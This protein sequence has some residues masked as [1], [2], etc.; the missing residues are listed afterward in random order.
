MVFAFPTVPRTLNGIMA[1]LKSE[2]RP[3]SAAPAS[4][5]GLADFYLLLLRVVASVP[6]VY[7]QVVDQT[8]L[9]WGFLWEQKDW[10]LVGQIGDLSLPQPSILAAV[11]V[12][13][14]LACAVGV[15]C[16]F[17]TRINAAICLIATAFLFLTGLPFSEWMTSQTYV[18]FLGLMLVLV[19]SGPGRF[20]FDGIFAALRRRKKELRSQAAL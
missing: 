14:L 17:L 16:G 19:I 7:Y 10:P 1:F 18:L 13:S 3:E 8:K 5:L 9:A 12:F 20:S 6:L 2:T 4:R 11:L 15:F